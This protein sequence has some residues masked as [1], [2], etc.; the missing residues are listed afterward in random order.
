VWGVNGNSAVLHKEYVTGGKGR[1]FIS[2]DISQLPQGT[3][4]I[5]ASDVNGAA[6]GSAKIIRM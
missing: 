6:K 4:I 5:K 3:W 2:V 1:Q